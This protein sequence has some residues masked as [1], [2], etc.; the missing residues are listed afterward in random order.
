MRGRITSTHHAKKNEPIDRALLCIIVVS[1]I[2]SR[3]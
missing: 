2:A 1:L 3:L